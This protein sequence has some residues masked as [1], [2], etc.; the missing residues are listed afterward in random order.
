MIIEKVNSRIVLKI[1]QKIGFIHCKIKFVYVVFLPKYLALL[2]QICSF[3]AKRIM[4]TH[5][6]AKFFER[7]V[8]VCAAVAKKYLTWLLRI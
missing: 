8:F 4:P 2:L 6:I 5:I 7:F 3:S 1:V